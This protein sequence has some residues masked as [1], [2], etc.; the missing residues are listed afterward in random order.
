MQRSKS[1]KK[2]LSPDEQTR[3]AYIVAALR[4]GEEELSQTEIAERLDLRPMQVSRLLRQAERLGF[5][6]KPQLTA[7]RDRELEADLLR[8][9]PRLRR[10]GVVLADGRVRLAEDRVDAVASCAAQFWSDYVPCQRGER[11]KVGLGG[12][13]AIARLVDRIETPGP[14]AKLELYALSNIP[15]G[16]EDVSSNTNVAILKRRFPRRDIVIH[17]LLAMQLSPEMKEK[18]I[19]A[20]RRRILRLSIV[21]QHF[22][23]VSQ[24]RALFAGIG[25]FEDRNL[26]NRLRGLGFDKRELP[27]NAI[28]DLIYNLI[29]EDDQVFH[30]DSIL[31]TRLI[32][33]PVGI[34]IDI[35]QRP[36]SL[37]TILAWGKEKAKPALAAERVGAYNALICDI[38][39]AEEMLAL[40]AGKKGL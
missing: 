11:T 32:T 26:W 6:S 14:N 13:R 38:E 36:D 7:G 37:V 17:Q 19:R 4:W 25:S 39:M 5:M 9:F 15:T 22:R 35:A 10:A 16:D 33:V 30:E 31:H 20:E 24:C 29:H 23:E 8:A 18:D 21:Q 3:L 27:R 12:G 34:F 1:N 40:V 2:A 28:G